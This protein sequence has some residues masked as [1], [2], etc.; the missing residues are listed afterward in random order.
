MPPGHEGPIRMLTVEHYELIRRRHFIDGLSVRAIAGELGHSRK[1]VVKALKH[2][3]PPG[4]RR[5]QPANRPVMDPFSA[6]VEAWMEQDRQRP[7]KQ[8]H[9][10]QRIYERL[11]EEHQ[12]TGASCTVRRYMNKRPIPYSHPSGAVIW[13][14]LPG[15]VLDLNT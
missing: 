6:I 5:S 2:A 3:I 10:A 9:T 15:G 7:R 8:R 4:Y 11:R 12:F 14:T 13:V 1:T